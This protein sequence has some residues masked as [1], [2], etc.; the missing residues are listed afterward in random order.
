MSAITKI[1]DAVLEKI[2]ISGELTTALEKKS[3]GCPGWEPT[4]LRLQNRLFGFDVA[5]R[6][7]H[8]NPGTDFVPYSSGPLGSYNFETDQ[9]DRKR[10]QQGG[11]NNV[12]TFNVPVSSVGLVPGFNPFYCDHNGLQIITRTMDDNGNITESSDTARVFIRINT[13]NSPWLPIGFSFSP[14][15]VSKSDN[16]VFQ[17][18]IEKFWLYVQTPTQDSTNQPFIVIALLRSAA[19]FGPGGGSNLYGSPTSTA[20]TQ[21]SVSQQPTIPGASSG[22]SP[23]GGSP[24]GGGSSGGGV[25]GQ[26]GRLR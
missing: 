11:I 14:Q 21:A 6:G 17:G 5:R 13:P 23:G 22:S 18:Y 10:V 1:R 19:L 7:I 26:G 9:Q 15:G 20:P 2:R 8:G 3:R 4:I 25:G 24:G 16:L 12:T